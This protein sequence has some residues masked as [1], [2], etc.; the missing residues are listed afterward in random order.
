MAQLLVEDIDPIILEKLEILAKEHD[1]FLQEGLKQREYDELEALKDL[2]RKG[3]GKSQLLKVCKLIE[4]KVS[5]S[6]NSVNY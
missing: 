4:N 1:R 2:A 5:N 3:F 6:T